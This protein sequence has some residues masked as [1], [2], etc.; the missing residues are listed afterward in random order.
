MRGVLFIIII[1]L[2][3]NVLIYAD[4][5][6]TYFPLQ[7]VGHMVR[8]DCQ[9]SGSTQLLFV[10]YGVLLRRLQGDPYLSAVT[11]IVLDEVRNVWLFKIR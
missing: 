8:G 2:L 4:F 6:L 3:A 1:L 10:T 9:A 7:V 5:Y 11:H